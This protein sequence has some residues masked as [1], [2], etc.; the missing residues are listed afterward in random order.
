LGELLLKQ[1]LW[2]AQANKYD[3]AYLTTFSGQGFLIEL[4]EYF[5]FRNTG[6]NGAGE[7]I[8]EKPLSRDPV[9][10]PAA[11]T[12]FFDAARMAYP[13]F[14]AGPK[15]EAY[16]I[17]IKEAFHED[18]FPELAKPK[19]PDLFKA[20]GGPKTP[21]NTIR[22]VYLCRAQA[23]IAQPGALLFF[24][25]SASKN[26]PSQ[27]VT[28]VGIF[29]SMALARSTEELRQLAG[30]RSVY[31]EWQLQSFAA[32]ADK[33]VKVINFLLAAHVS[34][35][36]ELAT[37]KRLGVIKGQPPQSIFRIARDNMLVLLDAIANLGFRVLS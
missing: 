24:Y 13:R 34:P 31:T 9:P 3:V 19:Q 30:G 20:V 22:K 35:V 29:E 10:L 18:L 6:T 23:N 37:L 33:P 26:P 16:G 15:V 36:I 21:G 8:Y 32:S 11:G 12:S 27:A 28:T 25:K 7:R 17:P 2:F 1:A 4:L 14:Y 5:G